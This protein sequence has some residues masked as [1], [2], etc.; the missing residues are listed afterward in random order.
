MFRPPPT[1]PLTHAQCVARAL[2]P[3]P[4]LIRRLAAIVYESTLLFGVVMFAGIVFGVLVDQKHAL[5]HRNGL[6]ATMFAVLALYFVGFWMRGGQT[7]AMKTWHLRL[8]R[9]DGL[10]VR[11]LQAAARFVLSWLW[12][13]PPLLLAWAMQWHSAKEITSLMLV[14]FVLYA[15]LSKALPQGQFL[16]DQI[17][18]TA[19]VDTRPDD[20]LPD[21][22]Q[23]R[24]P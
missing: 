11:P 12:F 9:R 23:A 5:A 21:H 8:L 1:P 10:P 18:R 22:T 15:L 13:F 3:A 2:Q 17:C 6:Q 20:A 24:K 7:L 14:W 16:H 4:A 19:L